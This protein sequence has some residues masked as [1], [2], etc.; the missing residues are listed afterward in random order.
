[1]EVG[2]LTF[3]F[4]IKHQQTAFNFVIKHPFIAFKNVILCICE[5]IMKNNF[6]TICLGML[7]ML[8]SS[9]GGGTSPSSE[10]SS[11]GGDPSITSSTSEEELKYNWTE[12]QAE[13][14]KG[15]AYGHVIPHP[16]LEGEF[17]VSYNTE[18]KYVEI[19]GTDVIKET[20]DMTAYFNL[21]NDGGY[22]YVTSN[23]DSSGDK[24]FFTFN[25]ELTDT[26][27]K[28]R[29]IQ[30]MSYI[31]NDT[32]PYEGWTYYLNVAEKGNLAI[33][34]KDSNYD[35]PVEDVIY[36]LHFIREDYAN[37]ILPPVPNE[38]VEEYA[39]QKSNYSI[40]CY[41]TD[42]EDRDDGG[43]SE[44]LRENA[45]NIYW[46]SN[47]SYFVASSPDLAY[48][49]FYKYNH[50]NNC[51]TIRFRR[52]IEVR[53]FEET[54][55]S[56]DVLAAFFSLMKEDYYQI[57]AVTNAYVD[58]IF[59]YYIE[60]YG[61]MDFVK[62]RGHID[63]DNINKSVIDGY[64]DTLSEAGWTLNPDEENE[65]RKV[66]KADSDGLYYDR[67][68]VVTP[69]VDN[70]K[71]S[72]VFYFDKLSHYF[73]SWPTNE[74]RE[75][76]Y[77]K[78]QTNDNIPVFKR[79]FEDVYIGEDSIIIYFDSDD[80]VG[81]NAAYYESLLDDDGFICIGL[82]DYYNSP[83]R[84][85]AIDISTSYERF[86]LNFGNPYD[87]GNITKLWPTKLLERSENLGEKASLIA[88]Y[89][90]DRYIVSNEEVDGKHVVTIQCLLLNIEDPEEAYYDENSKVYSYLSDNYECD[91]SGVGEV[92]YTY[93][94]SLKVTAIAQS[95]G[96]I[97]SGYLAITIQVTVL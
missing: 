64:F 4:V 81:S 69:T 38:N 37:P 56:I 42:P 47:L 48:T 65:Y 53:K 62:T 50:D 8:L 93:D 33:I 61:S 51:L 57:P 45:W 30:L 63:I 44:I 12:E 55:W 22:R 36:L 27:G 49:I 13:I 26:T 70:S 95:W 31:Y 59:T 14:I 15:Y 32:H 79:S 87:E 88:S 35:F 25:K 78:F 85:Y 97:V 16:Q 54:E 94:G 80:K 58:T 5:V 2:S 9:C 10:S 23:R 21:F 67:R 29:I 40:L 17:K 77:N 91:D 18:E 71:L 82:P 72:I 39:T 68:I 43:Y 24:T 86:Y 1:M 89:T 7:A 90:A 66:F 83:N 92:A 41:Y 6:F 73:T 19:F 46:N 3:N 20:K 28:K 84:K 11:T 52:Y 74:I 76:I 34:I 75:W 96:G 60:I